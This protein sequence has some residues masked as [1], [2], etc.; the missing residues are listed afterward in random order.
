MGT[1][2]SPRSRN[3][4]LIAHVSTSVGWFG[5]VLAF[6]SLAIVGLTADDAALAD[7]AYRAMDVIGWDVI[8]PLC[9]A[10][11]VT[12]VVQSLGTKWGLV[13]HYWVLFK[14]L[15]NAFA[16]VLLL[17]HMRPVDEL[18]RAA[19]SGALTADVHH[20]MRV[21]L[22]FDASA[23]LAVVLVANTLA[24]LK[25]RGMTRYGRRISSGA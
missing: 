3:V 18:A 19:A 16:T 20:G 22:V 6:L 21:Q 7:A 15:L 5:A 9:I 25:P 24:I 10:S 17:V 23:A 11:L 13:R 12:G 4:A 1:E 14:L 2:L 8:V